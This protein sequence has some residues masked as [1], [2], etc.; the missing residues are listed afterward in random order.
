MSLTG[1]SRLGARTTVVDEVLGQGLPTLLP[2]P[3]VG[4]A[5]ARAQLE[6]ARALADALAR[7]PASRTI[8]NAYDLYRWTTIAGAR[9]C[10][11]VAR[12][13]MAGGESK[14]PEVFSALRSE[15]GATDQ[16]HLA[17]TLQQSLEGLWTLL[18]HHPECK[19]GLNS[20]SGLAS[21]PSDAPPPGYSSPIRPSSLASPT[22]RALTKRHRSVSFS[23]S[24]KPAAAS[25]VKK[26]R[27]KAKTDTTRKAARRSPS[28]EFDE[29]NTD[30]ADSDF[31][32]DL[33]DDS[34]SADDEADNFVPCQADLDFEVTATL[35]CVSRA[36]VC[37]CVCEYIHW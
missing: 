4:T 24:T 22:P 17:A 18:Q 28:P 2:P 10:S 36:C 33:A 31:I 16:L 12:T 26:K 13:V 23:P 20:L 1:Q 34:G 6:A 3:L 7:C 14:Y 5:R 37:V 15:C 21:S 32:Q 19:V 11:V 27:K 35:V 25:P 8:E 9:Q 29:D 30:D